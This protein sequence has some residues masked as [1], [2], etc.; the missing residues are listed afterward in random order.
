MYLNLDEASHLK[1]SDC[2]SCSLHCCDGSRLIL[3]PIVLD[4]FQY[5]YEHFL[6]AFAIIDKK[7]RMVM[8]FSN[9]VKACLYYKKGACTIYNKRPPACKLYPLAPYYD[10]I[11][12]DS[13]CPALGHIGI[14]IVRNGATLLSRVNEPFYHARLENFSDK[15][16]DSDLFLQRLNWEFRPILELEGIML[17]TYTGAQQ[18]SFI[19]MHKASLGFLDEWRG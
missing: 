4:D 2:A 6:I 16:A 13:S 18:N 1:F 17:L 9:R 11:L 8:V 14:P 5:V 15:V 3:A 12:V 19:Q 7:L 10:E